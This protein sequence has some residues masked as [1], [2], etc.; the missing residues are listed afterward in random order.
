MFDVAKL[1]PK[2]D[3]KKKVLNTSQYYN[4]WQMIRNSFDKF[5]TL[6]CLF[7]LF[8]A[9]VT[10]LEEKLQLWNDLLMSMKL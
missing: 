5:L 3:G 10:K 9:K 8:Q 7:F 2:Y 4:N 6:K 1:T